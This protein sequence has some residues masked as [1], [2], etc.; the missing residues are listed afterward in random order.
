MMCYY[1]VESASLTPDKKTVFLESSVK[2]D[3][4]KY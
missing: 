2:G 1:S 4:K 3:D